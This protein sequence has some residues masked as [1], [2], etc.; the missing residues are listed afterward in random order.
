MLVMTNPWAHAQHTHHIQPATSNKNVYLTMM[1]TMMLQM[2]KAPTGNSPVA[3]FLHQM[4][5]HHQGAIAMAR[6]EITNGHNRE[7]IQ[8]AKSILIEQQSEVEQMRLWLKQIRADTTFQPAA[9]DAAMKQSMA[10][11]MNSLP[12]NEALSDTDRAFAAVMKPHHQA[13]LDMAKVALQ[14]SHEPVIGAYAR[15]LM[16]SQQIEIDQMTNYL[17]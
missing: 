7:M 15:G 9:F 3:A 1:D 12:P 11:M 2:D 17:R 6:Y 4:L 10:L 14:F 13:A 8:L 5:A 16:A